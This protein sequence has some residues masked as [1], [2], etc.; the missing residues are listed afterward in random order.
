MNRAACVRSGSNPLRRSSN[1]PEAPLVGWRLLAAGRGPLCLRWTG[2]PCAPAGRRLEPGEARLVVESFDPSGELQLGIDRSVIDES[3]SWRVVLAPATA[4]VV[5]SLRSDL[6]VGKR[7]RGT[8]P[9]STFAI[10]RRHD[11]FVLRAAAPAV[12]LELGAARSGRGTRSVPA[13]DPALHRRGLDE[14]EALV[15]EGLHLSR[16]M[17]G[18]RW[19]PHLLAGDSD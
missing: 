5:E 2:D 11:Q 12:K 10:C 6:H 16:D 3:G 17:V 9:I 13:A 7:F 8:L 4:V 15:T 18:R 19:R 14:V 1:T